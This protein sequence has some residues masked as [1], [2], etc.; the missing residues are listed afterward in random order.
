MG[1]GGSGHKRAERQLLLARCFA[2]E[3]GIASAAID[4]PYHGDRVS[5]LLAPQ[6]VQ[7]IIA[8]VGSDK[9]TESMVAD[10]SAA[11]DAL[12]QLDFING[13]KVAY[14]GLSMGTHFG[15]PFV[16]AAGSRLC[17]AA[18]G[19]N[20]MLAPTGMNMAP[21]FRQDAPKLTVPVLFHVQWDDEIFPREGQLELFDLIGSEDKCLVAYPG[22]HGGSAPAAVEAWFQF[23]LR[24]LAGLSS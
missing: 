21:R 18:L 14:M 9:V 6:Q 24:H 20:G 7:E 13:D 16:A 3:A 1:H 15:L 23:I 12:S 4:G 8:A 10:W 11:L 5:T 2:K 22:P 19:K 17:C